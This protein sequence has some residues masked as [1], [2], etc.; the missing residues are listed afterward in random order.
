M[1]FVRIPPESKEGGVVAITD[2]DTFC[3]CPYC[4]D[5][6]QVNLEE[7]VS[8]PEFNLSDTSVL[9]PRCTSAKR[10]LNVLL[11]SM[12]PDILSTMR[13]ERLKNER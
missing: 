3:L 7:Y 12:L 4:G 5:V 11:E 13:K 10:H 9:C 8:L 1:Y 2:L 6:V